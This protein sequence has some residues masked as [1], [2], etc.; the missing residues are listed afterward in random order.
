VSFT[1]RQTT[2]RVGGGAPIL[3][4][5]PIAAAEPVV[6]RGADCD[7]LLPDLAVSLR[8][9]RLR[10]TGPGRVEIQ[11]LGELPIE[12]GGRFPRA[13]ELALAGAPHVVI[14]SHVLTLTAGDG[15]D[16]VVVA[17]D[18]RP[19]LHGAPS[20]ADER[21][22]FAPSTVALGKRRLAWALGLGILLVCLVL[23]VAGF[24]L[25]HGLPALHA[26]RQWSSGPL[27]KAHAF[28]G[29][30][31]QSC[32]QFAFVAARDGACMA[33]HGANRSRASIQR[34]ATRV[35]DWGSPVAPRL[36]GDHAA[37]GRLIAATPLPT[38]LGP[39]IEAM[40]ARAFNHPGDRCASCHLEHQR[41]DPPTPVRPIPLL[42]TVNSCAACH[43]RLNERLA[44]TPLLDVPDWGRHPDFRPLLT[45]SARGPRPRLERIA[46]ATRPI[47]YPGLIF[48]HRVHLAPA[49]GVA[50]MAQ[51]LSPA[52][53]YG[54]PLTCA[55]CHRPD[56]LGRGFAPVEMV[57]DCSA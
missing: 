33:C 26:D 37:H 12:V 10:Q 4:T 24:F 14:G 52:K 47:E 39:R 3:R 32:H 50:R 20:A 35:R 16:E 38:A 17:V 9:A 40:F 56:G 11:S 23:P 15:P 19:G 53:G 42:V 45:V 51:V 21:E 57:R 41:P 31:C 2:P 49:G 48:S 30:R 1:L 36:I 22:V 5:R 25:G 13:A 27:S 54:A 43:A 29:A 6:G 55:S 44:S 46:L 8:H 34:M 7:I 18:R 28:L